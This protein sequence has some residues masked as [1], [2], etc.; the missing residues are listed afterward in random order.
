LDQLDEALRALP[1]ASGAAAPAPN[2]APLAHPPPELVALF[3]RPSPVA[4]A[5]VV[6]LRA[7][8]TATQDAYAEAAGGWDDGVGRG[9]QWRLH[10]HKHL[11]VY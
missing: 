8:G 5:G 3:R 1:G 10:I 9:G 2:V 4:G 6:G 11:G 7:H